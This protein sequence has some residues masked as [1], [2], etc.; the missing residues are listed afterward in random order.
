MGYRSNVEIIVYGKPEIFDAF[1]ASIRLV[2][3]RVFT[4]WTS[5]NNDGESVFSW[6]DISHHDGVG[7]TKLMQFKL[8]DV[9]WYDGYEAIDAWE[10][11]LLPK[12]VDVGLNWELARVGE[13]SDDVSHESDGDDVDNFLYLETHIN[14][15]F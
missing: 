10:K 6:H 15:N 13:D 9:K 2:N 14:R 3:H 11:D 1:I 12:A 4:D 8:D 7:V 5:W